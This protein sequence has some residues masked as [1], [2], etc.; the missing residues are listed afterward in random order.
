V[1]AFDLSQGTQPTIQVDLCPT[2]GSSTNIGALYLRGT[3]YFVDGAGSPSLTGS[4]WIAVVTSLNGMGIGSFSPVGGGVPI[5]F[6][7]I[8]LF[9]SYNGSTVSSIGLSFVITPPGWFGTV[10]IDELKIT[11]N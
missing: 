8:S 4:E 5:V 2:A 9:D 11:N 10:F 3:I 1:L 7:P 6:G